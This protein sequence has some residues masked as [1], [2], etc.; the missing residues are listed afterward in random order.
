MSRIG[1]VC[2]VG[3]HIFLGAFDSPKMSGKPRSIWVAVLAGGDG[4][5]L[6]PLTT[7]ARGIST[8]TQYCSLNGGRSLL[9]ISLQRALAVTSRERIVT[10]VTEAH[11]GWWE[12]E[13]FAS[14]RSPV[15]VQPCN[16]GTGLGV[17]LALLVIAKSDPEAGV[18]FIPSD[19]YVEHEAVLA[20]YL[21]EAAAPEVMDSDKLT[22]LGMSPYAPD[23][24]FGYLSPAPDSG[25][26]MRPVLDELIR[27]G[28]VWNR[29]IIAGRISQFIA[30]YPRHTRQMI[31]D[32]QSIVEHWPDSRVPPAGLISLYARHSALD[33]SRD[34]LQKRPESLQF[35]N[36]PPCGWI[37]VGTPER[38][39]SVLRV[40]PS[41]SVE[42]FR[43][44]P[45]RTFNLATAFDRAAF[46]PGLSPASVIDSSHLQV[47]QRGFAWAAQPPRLAPYNES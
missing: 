38:L 3:L 4:N 15:V 40:S 46:K 26:G 5:R 39:A 34:V 19:H 16:R 10:V 30:L 37:D 33:F 18:L 2:R 42:D 41:V 23:S 27:A 12:H 17:L 45:L 21:R 47:T 8:P 36:V 13:F 32:L 20:E 6:R 11:R 44:T 1:S 7:N 14:P 24:G 28:S 43:F 9:Q 22:L 25:V 31:L 35:L 29:G